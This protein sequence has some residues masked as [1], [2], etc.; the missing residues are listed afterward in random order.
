AE[1]PPVSISPPA[2]MKSGIASRTKESAPENM[3]CG[4]TRSGAVSE[5]QSPITAAT[6]TAKATGAVRLIMTTKASTIAAMAMGGP[7]LPL[8]RGHGGRQLGGHDACGVGD[9]AAH[10]VPQVAQ[11]EEDHEDPAHRHHEIE[12]AEIP[13]HDRRGLGPADLG[14]LRAVDH[15][16]E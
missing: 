6:P 5:S 8:L 1:M 7:L 4:T 3:C 2:R 14:D 11:R 15:H 9:V 10:G 12:V 16:D 13:A